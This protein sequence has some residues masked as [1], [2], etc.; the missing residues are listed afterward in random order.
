VRGL[1]VGE[2]RVDRA[3]VR[4]RADFLDPTGVAQRA[5]D[6]RERFE[7]ISPGSFRRE[8]QKNEVDRADG[9]SLEDCL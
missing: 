5:R 8:E 7:V 9:D 4:R 1:I 6:P 2:Q 3:G